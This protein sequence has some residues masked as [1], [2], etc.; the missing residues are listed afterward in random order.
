MT[1]PDPAGTPGETILD[2]IIR[3]GITTPGQPAPRPELPGDTHTDPP[4]YD[5]PHASKRDHR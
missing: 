4:R 1:S 2:H 5:P 3:H